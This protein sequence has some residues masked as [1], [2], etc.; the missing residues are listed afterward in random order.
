MEEIAQVDVPVGGHR[1]VSPALALHGSPDLHD[2]AVQDRD[3]PLGRRVRDLLR[4]PLVVLL[5]LGE[6]VIGHRCSP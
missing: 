5:E 3:R 1:A 4:E 6:H 2:H